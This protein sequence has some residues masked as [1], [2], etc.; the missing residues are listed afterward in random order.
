M[1]TPASAGSSSPARSGTWSRICGGQQVRHDIDALADLTR[2]N[3]D[4]EKSLRQVRELADAKLALLEETTQLRR[5]SGLEATLPLLLTDRDK[6]LMDG[7]RAVVA[8]MEDRE[9]KLLGQRNEAARISAD[10]TIWTITVWM[11]VALLALGVAAVVLMRTVRFGGPA[12]L[13]V[14]PGRKWAVLPLHYASAVAVVA[15][16]AALRWRLQDSFGALPLFL[17]FYPAVLLVAIIGGGGPGIVATVLATLAADYW[18]ISP[19]YSFRVE[20]PNNVLALGIFAG[21]CLFLSMLGERLRRARWTEAISVA[22]EQQLQELS[23]LNEELSQQSEELS[24]QSE[25]LARQNE[26]LQ[27]QS[28]EIQGLNTE[29][30]HR[31]DMLQKLLDAARLSSHRAG[32]DAGHLRGGQGDVRTGRLGRARAGAARRPAGGPRAG[33]AGAGGRED[34]ILA[35]GELLRGA[36]HGRE[37]DGR[38]DRCR[39]PPGSRAGPTAGRATVPGRPG[40]ADAHARDGPSAPWASTAAR[41]R[42]GRPS[43]SAWPN[44]WPRSAATSWKPCGCKRRTGAAGGDRRVFRRCHPVQGRPRRHPDLERGGRT[45]LRL[46]GGGGRRPTDRAPAAAGAD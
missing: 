21:T 29:L 44:G 34:R 26:E 18:F 33:R 43:S 45:P 20:A 27:T 24:Q 2:D 12:A 30:K 22:Q 38:F 15:V 28:E 37:Q 32:G 10:R 3:A 40:R 35:R 9:Q 14:M 25:E 11:P 36:G 8:E 39:A 5:K 42:S 19:L 46:P 7:L 4:Q 41:H 23:R 16:A 6:K 17:T 13:P 1:R 31:E